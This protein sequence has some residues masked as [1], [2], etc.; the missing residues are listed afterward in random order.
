MGHSGKSGLFQWPETRWETDLLPIRQ[1]TFTEE[2][3]D[4][5]PAILSAFDIVIPVYHKDRPLAY[6]LISNPQVAN[7]EKVEDKIK[8]AQTVTNIIP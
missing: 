4:P 6:L 7:L 8:F 2:L 3:A 5:K 1:L